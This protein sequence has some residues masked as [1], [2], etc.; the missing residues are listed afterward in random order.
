MPVG[1]RLERSDTS[2]FGAAC[3][4]AEEESGLS[5]I[6]EETILLAV[7]ENIHR[8]GPDRNRRMYWFMGSFHGIPRAYPDEGMTD[9]QAY[10]LMRLP[11]SEMWPAD[12][13]WLFPVLRNY[14][15]NPQMPL[16]QQRYFYEH[17]SLQEHEPLDVTITLPVFPR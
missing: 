8:D 13:R 7:V 14:E 1:G 17:G 12:E 3:R 4:E 15:L 11:R 2:L 16:H 6:L 10:S 9:P 5:P